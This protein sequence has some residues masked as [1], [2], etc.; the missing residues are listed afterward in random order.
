VA[1]EIA[2]LREMNHG[3]RFWR[4]V[5]ELV[6]DPKAERAWLSRNGSRLRRYG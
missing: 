5:A 6:G 4:L 1:H 2:H 3:A